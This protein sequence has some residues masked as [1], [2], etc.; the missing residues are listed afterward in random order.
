MPSRK[1]LSDFTGGRAPAPTK[2]DKGVFIYESNRR[3]C[4]RSRCEMQR[5]KRS[6]ALQVSAELGTARGNVR[7][8]EECGI[9]TSRRIRK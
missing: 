9:R 3:G 7:R 5:A 2:C 8:I 4:E 1:V 6:A